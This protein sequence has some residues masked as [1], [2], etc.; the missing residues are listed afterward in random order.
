MTATSDPLQQGRIDAAR[1]L[2]LSL[3][4]HASEAVR[5]MFEVAKAT[6][7][8]AWFFYPLYAVGTDRLDMTVE[9]AVKEKH[10]ERGGSNRTDYRR[11]II[12]LCENQHISRIYAK[13]C[14]CTAGSQ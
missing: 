12:W 8:Y 7:F 3:K 2:S 14:K 10:A 1:L 9:L 13:N 6:M 5:N 4:Q 11:S